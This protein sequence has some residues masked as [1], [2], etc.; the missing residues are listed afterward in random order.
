MSYWLSHWIPN[1][2]VPSSK[3]LGHSK[4][5]LAFHPSKWIPGPPGDLLVKTKLSPHSGFIALRQLNLIHEKSLKIFVMYPFLV[6][7]PTFT[8]WKHQRTLDFLVFLG[9]YNASNAFRL[10]TLLKR[11]CGTGAFLWILQNF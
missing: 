11:D 9:E 4:V 7:G 8:L 1:P 2:G 10:A 6:N 3:P 5:D